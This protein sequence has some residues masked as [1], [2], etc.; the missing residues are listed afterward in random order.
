MYQNYPNPFRGVSGTTI[1][2]SVVE[3][4]EIVIRIFDATGRLVN[5]IAEHAEAGDNRTSWNGTD[6]DGHPVA[7]GVYFY[8]IRGDAFVDQ[9]KMLLLH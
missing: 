3:A 9:K 7:G 1:H 4:G 8:E 2:Y 6:R 5:E